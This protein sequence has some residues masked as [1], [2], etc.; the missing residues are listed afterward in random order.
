MKNL[1]LAI[2]RPDPLDQRTTTLAV[3]NSQ[4]SLG[5]GSQQR[6][7]AGSPKAVAQASFGRLSSPDPLGIRTI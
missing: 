6:D 3:P 2:L 5:Q 1:G 7:V 4:T